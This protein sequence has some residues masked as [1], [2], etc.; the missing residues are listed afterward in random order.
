MYDAEV[1]GKRV[2]VQH[3]PLGG[4]LGWSEVEGIPPAVTQ[5]AVPTRRPDPSLDSPLGPTPLRR[6]LM[7]RTMAPTMSPWAGILR[8]QGPASGNGL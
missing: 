6:G 3:V 4:L 8:E 1:L 2:V 5:A 7:P